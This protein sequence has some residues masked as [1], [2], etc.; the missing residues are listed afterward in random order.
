MTDKAGPTFLPEPTKIV[1]PELEKNANLHVSQN[2]YMASEIF[3]ALRQELYDNWRAEPASI[4]GES[5]HAL[6]YYSGLMVTNPPAF[7]EIM[8]L[9][10]GLNLLFDSANEEGICMV[11]FNALRKKRGVSTL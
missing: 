3:N 7:V 1:L 5:G 9:E 4:A 8:S 10:L 11:I 2:V 6:W